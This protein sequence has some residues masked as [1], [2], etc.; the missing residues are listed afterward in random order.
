MNPVRALRTDLRSALVDPAD[1]YEVCRHYRVALAVRTT[2][3]WE[4]FYRRLFEALQ[5]ACLRAPSDSPETETARR[6][7]M[8]IL[9]DDFGT[10]LFGSAGTASRWAEPSLTAP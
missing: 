1:A 6:S 8:L 3:S 9:Q 2:L 7:L 5:L 10:E 4:R